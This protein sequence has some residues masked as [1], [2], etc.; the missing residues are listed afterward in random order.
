MCPH[1]PGSADETVPT[2]L[3]CCRLSEAFCACSSKEGKVKGKAGLRGAAWISGCWS[4]SGYI[5]Y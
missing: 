2:V 1:N 4:F 5:F 3:G